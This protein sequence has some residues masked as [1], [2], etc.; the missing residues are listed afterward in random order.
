MIPLPRPVNTVVTILE[1]QN[2]GVECGSGVGVTNIE[3]SNVHSCR[4][5]EKL[6]SVCILGWI[7]HPVANANELTSSI[8]VL[9]R[10]TWKLLCEKNIIQIVTLIFFKILAHTG[11]MYI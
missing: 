8:S 4:G 5:D 9:P 3:D 7:F 10:Q 2:V 11:A 6:T 1:L